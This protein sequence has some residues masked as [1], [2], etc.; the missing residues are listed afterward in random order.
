MQ[1]VA[2]V[3]KLRAEAAKPKSHD[4]G[5]GAGDDGISQTSDRALHAGI[6]GCPLPAK[7]LFQRSGT[8][9]SSGCLNAAGHS[10]FIFNWL[11]NS[12]DSEIWVILA[13]CSDFWD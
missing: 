2:E 11:G 7:F 3:V 1:A 8:C 9:S 5:Y 12:A 6:L 13:D 10:R 4:F